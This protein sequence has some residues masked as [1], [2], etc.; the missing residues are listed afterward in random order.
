MKY[1][2]FICPVC[3]APLFFRVSPFWTRKDQP[4][5]VPVVVPKE[6]MARHRIPAYDNVVN[7]P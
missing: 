1:F 7:Y 2:S 6:S 5:S 3:K 4:S